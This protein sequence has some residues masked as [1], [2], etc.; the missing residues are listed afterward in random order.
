M[1]LSI[2]IAWF[3]PGVS[4]TTHFKVD[5]LVKR[6]SEN[7]VQL[8]VYVGMINKRGG[9]IQPTI[10]WH[11]HR[12]T[13]S[14]FVVIETNNYDVCLVL[15]LTIISKRMMSVVLLFCCNN[16][17]HLSSMMIWIWVTTIQSSGYLSPVLPI[18]I[19][20]NPQEHG[21]SHSNQSLHGALHGSLT[22][23]CERLSDQGYASVA[24]KLPKSLCLGAQVVP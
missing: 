10:R 3:M 19:W 16:Y 6:S 7:K 9:N 14:E 4:P 2:F 12:G 24:E 18:W 11:S 1:L 21:T 15:V 23:G 13:T 8:W 5:G 20:V 17:K 22:P